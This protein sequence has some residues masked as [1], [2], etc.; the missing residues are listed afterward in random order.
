MNFHE[1]IEERAKGNLKPLIELIIRNQL[2]ILNS[3]ESHLGCALCHGPLGGEKGNRC[4]VCQDEDG[5]V[6]DGV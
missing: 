3:L 2:P 6:R 5:K 1:A 4:P